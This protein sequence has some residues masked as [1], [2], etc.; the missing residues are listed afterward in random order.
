MKMN[1]LLTK[2]LYTCSYERLE[3]P[4]IRRRFPQFTG[5][6]NL[7]AL[8]QADGGIVTANL[9]NAVHVQLARAHGA[10]IVENTAVTSISTSS[11][12]D[13]VLV[14]ACYFYFHT[15]DNKRLQE[16]IRDCRLQE[17]TGDE[18]ER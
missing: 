16:T 11:R 9:A 4:E 14:Y 17:T 2:R 10:T 15:G 1:W 6:D 18:K 13:T 12:D 8:Y 5:P 7:T 3:A